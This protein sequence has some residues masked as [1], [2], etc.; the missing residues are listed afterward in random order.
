VKVVIVEAVFGSLRFDGTYAKDFK[1]VRPQVIERFI[2]G[3]V[4]KGRPLDQ[5]KLDKALGEV[6][7]LAGIK[8]TSA[9]QA[10]EAEGTTDVLLKVQDQKFLNTYLSVDN[11]GGRQ[12]GRYKGLAYVTF[13]SPLGYGESVNL[14]ALHSQGSDYG[15][16][17]FTVPVGVHGLLVGASASVMAYDVIASEFATQEIRGHSSTYTATVQYPLMKS[18]LGKLGLTFEADQKNFVNKNGTEG[19]TSDYGLQVYSVTLAG[20]YTDNFL[21]GAMTSAS[22]DLG[23][24]HVDL[25]GSPN[26]ASDSANANTQGDFS[27]LRWNVSRNQFFADTVSLNLNA[28][29]QFADSN[30][31]S[32]EKFYLGGSSGVRAYPT[33]EGGGSEGYLLSAELRKY[34]PYDLSVSTFVDYGYVN[35]YHHNAKE[36][37]P[38]AP[39]AAVN[40]YHLSGYGLAAAW[41]GPYSTTV[42]ATYA[43]RFGNNPNPAANGNDQDGDRTLDVFWLSG[44]VSF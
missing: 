14:T 25:E 39:L 18:Q 44:S 8:V 37:D 7:N 43:H 24:G 33:S 41:Q 32:S 20:D 11:A 27:R 34:L 40:G 5:N 21:A 31:D 4:E 9:L 29:G 30:L 10:G 17:G 3:S 42:K 12:T 35:Q 26:Q 15:K 38:S 16:L 22:I 1:R 36:S 19:T 2:G 13:A 28:S 23:A 6:N